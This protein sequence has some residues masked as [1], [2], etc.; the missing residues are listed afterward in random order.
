MARNSTLIILRNKNVKKRFG[1]LSTKHP[2]WKY[3]AYLEELSYEFYISKRTI[4]AILNNEA[5]YDKAV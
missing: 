3:E 4:Q 2:R 5:A 1:Q